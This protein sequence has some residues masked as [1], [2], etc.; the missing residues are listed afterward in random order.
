M[1]PPSFTCDLASA[2][3]FFPDH[4]TPHLPVL[5]AFGHTA[6]HEYRLR[7]EYD[8][9]RAIAENGETL[10]RSVRSISRD[11]PNRHWDDLTFQS[12]P[13]S[14]LHVDATHLRA[15]AETPAA[16]EAAATV[17]HSTYSQ[18][19]EAQGGSFELIRTGRNILTETVVL[20]ATTII[21]EP[22]F[23]LHYGNSSWEWHQAF[24]QQLLT[25][26]HGLSI[27]EGPPGTGKTSYLRHLMAVLNASHRFYFIPTASLNVLSKPD[28][29]GFWAEQRRHY[30]TRQFVVILEDSDAILS[31]RDTGNRDEVN[32]LLNL[33]DGMLADF[34]RLQIICTINCPA[35][36]IDPALRR[37]GRL[38]THRRFPRLTYPEAAA[39]AET[40]GQPLVIAKD[41]S[42]AEVF[43]GTSP[44][45]TVR[46]RIGFVG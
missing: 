7:G 21:P 14:F 10:L 20:P 23:R 33:S 26:R 40:L 34:L 45:P 24:C 39:L 8:L 43:A 38:H 17:F 27:L 36:D 31:T 22:S 6:L 25:G 32:A 18:A 4:Q 9:P 19:P 16:A 5:A 35:D 44:Q 13:H 30:A 2:N 41:Y 42:L 28:F 11:D 46:V 15:Y 29:I 37:P 12:G 3:A 1:N